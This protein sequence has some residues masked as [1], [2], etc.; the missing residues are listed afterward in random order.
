MYGKDFR[1][2]GEDCAMF[3]RIMK[4][5]KNSQVY[6]YLVIS[7]SI[8]V[9][10]KGSTTKNIANLGNIKKIKINNINQLI[11]GFI[12]IFSLEK[13]SL[14]EGVEI[15]ESLEYGSIIFWQKIW[16]QLNLSNIIKKQVKLKDKSIKLEV[17]KYIQM[18]TINRCTNPSSK[19]A[20]TRWIETTCYKQMKEYAKVPL[21]VNY[22]Y[23]SMD[24]LLKIKD[25]LE[26][27]IFKKLENIFSINVKLTA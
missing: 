21:E 11:D 17:E 2:Y 25:G 20:T 13:Y 8:Y 10:G 7:E 4:F 16:D 5:I 12:K 23:R 1:N 15:I 18:M 19:L 26:L 24:Q 6:E 9:K 22:F 14:T 3:P 27:A